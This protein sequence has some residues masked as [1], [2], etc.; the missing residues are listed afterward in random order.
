MVSAAVAS[1]VVVEVLPKTFGGGFTS[2]S[3]NIV[4]DMSSRS[5]TCSVRDQ[6]WKPMPLEE[7]C[8]PGQWETVVRLQVASTASLQGQCERPSGGAV[9]AYGRGIQL[10]SM[11][12][13]MTT[14]GL[15][16]LV[17]GTSQGFL[18]SKNSYRLT[19]QGSTLASARAATSNGTT[20]LPGGFWGWFSSPSGNLRC[21]L[22]ADSAQCTVLEHTWKLDDDPEPCEYDD[23]E[24]VVEAFVSTGR[25][26]V[27][28][29]CRPDQEE[30]SE[31]P[32]GRGYLVGDLM[33]SSSA[34]G[35]ACTNVR[36]KHGFVVGKS[37]YRTF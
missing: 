1:P 24:V 29:T 36:T 20:K 6:P 8:T 18:V 5:I 26:N 15:E 32:Y 14:K 35:M 17:M 31:L 28:T 11:R 7:G 21:S 9:L 30:R 19:T 4:C 10:G 13:G 37:A 34:Q 2:P 27:Y 25:G 22:S 12:C 3:G 23:A 16:C 33:C